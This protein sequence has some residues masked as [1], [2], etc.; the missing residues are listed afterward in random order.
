MTDKQPCDIIKHELRWL[1]KGNLKGRVRIGRT[2]QVDSG[3]FNITIEIDGRARDFSLSGEQ[4]E[5]RHFTELFNRIT[6]WEDSL[7]S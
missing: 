3:T 6:T 2:R 7:F 1:D 5:K 4:Y